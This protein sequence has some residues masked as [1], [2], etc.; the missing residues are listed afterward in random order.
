MTKGGERFSIF[1]V[2]TK[3]LLLTDFLVFYI[4]TV[5]EDFVPLNFISAPTNLINTSGNIYENEVCFPC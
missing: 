3:M 2:K 5:V 1:S 4:A